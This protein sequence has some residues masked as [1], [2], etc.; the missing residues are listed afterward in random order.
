MFIRSEAV[1]REISE[2]N[3]V[4]KGLERN[5]LIVSPFTLGITEYFADVFKRL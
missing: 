4:A 5:V 1:Y 2:G 3:L